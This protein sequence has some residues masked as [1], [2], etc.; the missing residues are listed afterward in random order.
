MEP[1]NGSFV[2][3]RDQ[4]DLDDSLF[5][6]NFL[7]HDGGS[8][9]ELL[10]KLGVP[11]ISRGTY[12][13][14]YFLPHVEDLLLGCRETHGSADIVLSALVCLLKEA[15]AW[16]EKDPSFIPMLREAS[17]V[18]HMDAHGELSLCKASELFD[19]CIPE[20]F[21]LLD[22]S[23]FPLPQ[24]QAEGLLSVLRV[25]GLSQTL[26]WQGVLA[27]AA[28]IGSEQNS[29]TE[30][31]RSER[32]MH[33]LLFLD[34]NIS[35]LCGTARSKLA[36]TPASSSFLSIVSFFRPAEPVQDRVDP[37]MLRV[38]RTELLDTHWL[39]CLSRGEE[40]VLPWRWSLHM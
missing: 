2:C 22:S 34:K 32:G 36:A 39:P 40:T 24:F 29:E 1:S 4:T 14:D 23:F 38:Y 3:I 18:P 35:T 8:E 30:Q 10:G 37:E 11:C 15:A 26:T 12:F 27:C 20:L 13:M 7:R 31:S 19:P 28:S 25:L 6:S 9:L 17:L 5:P 33:L 21:A 16:S